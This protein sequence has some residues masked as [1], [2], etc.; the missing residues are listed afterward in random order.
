MATEGDKAPTQGPGMTQPPQA[1]ADLVL[2]GGGVKGTALIGAVAAF[3]EAG[4]RFNRVAGTSAGALVAALV[5]AG[6]PAAELR[7]RFLALDYTRFRDPVKASHFGLRLAASALA[8]IVSE[9]MYH[10]DVLRETVADE[11]R[12]AGVTTF[13]DL[14]LDDPGIDPSVPADA[15][16]R[17]VVVGSDIT[18][19][20][21]VRIPWDVRAA[22]GI[23][24]DELKVA[25]AIRI[26]TSL[27][28]FYVPF[29]LR[30]T[31]T[32]QES[33]MMDG[34]LVSGFPVQ[35]FDRTDKRPPRWPTFR[36]ALHTAVPAMHRVPEVSS[37]LDLIRAIVHT[38]LHGRA[39]AECDDPEVMSRTVSIGT[40]YVDT[41]DFD[42]DQ[43]TRQRLFDDGYAA[44]QAFL[45]RMGTAP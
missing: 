15:R 4:Y 30:S 45:E 25:D 9:G 35:I 22:Y 33:L 16:Y 3:E 20:R 28:F 10:G 26:S 40:G 18:R 6:I 5:A 38:G 44:T 2:E 37:R 8:E 32:G 34:G 13:A 43:G 23:D 17:L 29:R 31:I 1:I 7:K 21:M 11:L 36:V 12:N 39:N 41:T 19:Q 27:P 24:P 14:R 42:I